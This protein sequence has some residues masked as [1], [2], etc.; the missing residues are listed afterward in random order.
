MERKKR[1][2]TNITDNTNTKKVYPSYSDQANRNSSADSQKLEY[3]TIPWKTARIKDELV[4]EL[5]LATTYLKIDHHGFTYIVFKY[6]EKAAYWMYRIPVY[7]PLP[8]FDIDLQD[9]S[10]KL[11]H[12][13]AELKKSDP[14]IFWY[15]VKISVAH[16]FEN[17]NFEYF[18]RSVMRDLKIR[19][20]R[21]NSTIDAI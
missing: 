1:M 9:L 19:F 15:V 12:E 2:S 17:I 8:P 10:T 14:R 18:H 5:A 7:R 3:E 4:T 6:Y 20:V 11:R 13:L 21:A 16:I